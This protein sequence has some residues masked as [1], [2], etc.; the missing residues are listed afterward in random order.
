MKK[1]ADIRLSAD[2]LK[3]KLDNT[4]AIRLEVAKRRGVLNTV[5]SSPDGVRALR[6]IMEMCGYD[7]SD[8]AADPTT[9]EI[10]ERGTLYNLARRTIYVELRRQI[11]PETLMKVEFPEKERGD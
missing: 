2:D 5:F 9:G 11:K 8:F 10:Q 1:T 7:K 3:K 6:I 4:E